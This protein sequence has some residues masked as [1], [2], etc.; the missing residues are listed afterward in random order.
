[1]AQG[2]SK[3]IWVYIRVQSVNELKLSIDV[4]GNIII[5]FLVFLFGLIFSINEYDLVI[6]DFLDGFW[7]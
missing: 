6:P 2:L 3:S 1:M 4:K 5:S 7:D